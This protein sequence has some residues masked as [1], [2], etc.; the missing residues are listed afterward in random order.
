MRSRYL[1]AVLI[2]AGMALPSPAAEAPSKEKIAR[3]IEQ[4]GSG[5]FTERENATQQLAGIGVPALEAL[6]KAVKSG[7]AEIRKRA[8]EIIPQIEVQAENSRILAPKHVHLIYKDTPLSEAVADFQK[9]SGY[10]LHLFDPQGKLKNRKITLDTGETSFWHAFALFRDKSELTEPTMQDLNQRAQASVIPPWNGA[11]GMP[12]QAPRA[13]VYPVL[14]S[15]SR[16]GANGQLAL[17]DGKSRQLPTDDRSAVRI[18]A[19]DRANVFGHIPASEIVVP[20]EVSAEPRLQWQSFQSV[21]V[22][23]A[24]D[25]RD[26][27]LTQV[28]PQVEGVAAF[29]GNRVIGLPGGGVAMQRAGLGGVLDQQIPLRFKKGTKPAKALKE[30]R[31]TVKAQLLTEAQPMIMADKLDKSAGQVF[32]GECGGSIK[33]VAVNA[34]SRQTTIQLEF[35]Q[36]PY[37]RVVPAQQDA[38]PAVVGRPALR[39]P[40]AKMVPAV[41]PGRL[42]RPAPNL[43]PPPPA[44]PG[45][46]QIQVGVGRGGAAVGGSMRFVG[47]FNGLTV[48]DD[49]GNALPIQI[50]QTQFRVMPQGPGRRMPTLIYTLVCAHEKDRGEPAKVVYLG[51]KR[52]TIEIPFA[53]QDVPLP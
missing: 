8:E 21:R 37:D 25:D 49:K 28:V 43:A 39:V 10:P 48:Q 9:Q 14:V 4:M 5:I 35:E 20:L 46:V 23:K 16:I 45:A 53:L 17:M 42:G 52:M 32:K 2:V 18:R 38:M 6:R 26:Q 19:L 36:P 22:D 50:Q 13:G 24:V 29:N 3:L 33:I 15:H 40:A 12:A 51:R 11:P 41:P 47:P 27:K 30:L 1:L 31:G 44:P 7:D 34:E